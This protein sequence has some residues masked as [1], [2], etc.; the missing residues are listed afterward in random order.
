MSFREQD[1]PEE[2][3]PSD[4]DKPSLSDGLG[5]RDA[6]VP[7]GARRR[8]RGGPGLPD[9]ARRARPGDAG[10]S[11]GWCGV[12]IA[13]PAE[14]AEPFGG[15]RGD[16]G[17]LARRGPR[18]RRTTRRPPSRPASIWSSD[19]GVPRPGTRRPTRSG[20]RVVEVL[21]DELVADTSGSSVRCS[22]AHSSTPSDSLRHIASVIASVGHAPDGASINRRSTSVRAPSTDS[23]SSQRSVSIAR[24]LGLRDPCGVA[25]RLGHDELD[26]RRGART[27]RARAPGRRPRR[28]SGRAHAV[29]LTSRDG[30]RAPA[31]G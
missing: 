2:Q 3:Q 10:A 11:S 7:A 18:W 23:R 8:D 30:P 13:E 16:R 17:V 15:D 29:V 1:A 27:R 12:A 22:S 9:P 20:D 6:G 26:R 14:R 24:P 4:V 28:R 19:A 5:L 21:L 25:A 31:R